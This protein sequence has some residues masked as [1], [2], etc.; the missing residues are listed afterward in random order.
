MEIRKVQMTGGSSFAVSLPKTWIK[1]QN[2]KKNDPVG[3][4]I[5]PDNSIVITTKITGERIDS[6][7]EFDV[8]TFEDSDFLFRSLIGSYIAGFD[9]IKINSKHRMPPFARKTVRNFVQ[10]T[11]GQEVFE[12][13]DNTIVIKDLLN[14]LEM[15]FNSTIR[16][17]HV[18]AK[19]MH[20]DASRILRKHD[21]D[22]AEDVISRDNDVDRLH[23]LIARQSSILLRNVNLAEKLDIKP[24]MIINYFLISR[25]IERIGDHAVYMIKNMENLEDLKIDKKIIDLIIT[26][27]EK[28][29]NILDKS[30]DSLFKKRI[31][32]ANESI[33]DVPKIIT[34]CKKINTEVLTKKG[35]IAIP[36]GYIV[37]SIR[38]SAVYSGDIAEFVINNI[39]R[40]EM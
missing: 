18:I 33:K 9:I 36:L 26:A 27:D 38:R 8:D 25:F 35:S 30:I 15:P 10:M 6:L 24:G 23:W 11:I 39:V 29:L 22:L 21:K 1:S 37:E 3:I 7:K 19:S 13:T 32:L 20:Q 16:R 17:M 5:Q 31:K 28:T 12:E 40:E 4:V 14:P 34:M 2:I